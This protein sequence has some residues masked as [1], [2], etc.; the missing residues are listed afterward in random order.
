MFG[1]TDDPA[2]LEARR[3]ATVERIVPAI[4]SMPGWQT[5]VE[6]AADD[7]SHTTFVFGASVEQMEQMARRVLTSPL[8]PHEDRALLPGPQRVEL[9][10]VLRAATTAAVSP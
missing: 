6:C 5:S 10:R 3:V 2:M 4:E 8:L 1:A 7:G 9:H